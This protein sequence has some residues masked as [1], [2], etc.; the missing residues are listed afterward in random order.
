MKLW[1]DRSHLSA[2]DAEYIS[3]SYAEDDL[4]CVRIDFEYTEE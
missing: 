4:F 2:M 3:R 1:Y